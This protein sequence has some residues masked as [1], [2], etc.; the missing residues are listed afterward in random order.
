MKTA[1]HAVAG[2]ALL[3]SQTTQAGNITH[4]LKGITA[5]QYRTSFTIAGQQCVIDRAKWNTALQSVANQSTKLRLISNQKWLVEASEASKD[6][7]Q[8]Y[9]FMPTLKLTVIAVEVKAACAG[10]LDV[11][12]TVAGADLELWRESRAVRGDPDSF[13]TTMVEAGEEIMQQFLNDWTDENGL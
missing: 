2:F 10:T 4:H 11:S 3:V 9:A 8:T 12:L 7:F 13:T 5:L 6:E 1:G